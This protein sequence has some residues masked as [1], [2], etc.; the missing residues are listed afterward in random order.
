MT[1]PNLAK[2][3][4]HFLTRLVQGT[5]DFTDMILPS[6]QNVEQSIEKDGTSRWSIRTGTLGKLIHR[7]IGGVTT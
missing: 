7:G 6:L 3:I 2:R 4:P 1:Q 5:E